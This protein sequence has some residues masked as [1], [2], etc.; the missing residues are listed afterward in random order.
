MQPKRAPTKRRI[1]SVGVSDPLIAKT[2]E[3]GAVLGNPIRCEGM[4]VDT[5][6]LAAD[7]HYSI[8][9]GL[10]LLPKNASPAP[11][12]SRMPEKIQKRLTATKPPTHEKS[13]KIAAA[14]G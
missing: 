2:R 5:E 8:V 6:P 3:Y 13:C 7:K 1:T 9:T 4:N 11:M 10:A 12:S 14:F